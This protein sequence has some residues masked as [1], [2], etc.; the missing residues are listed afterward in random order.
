MANLIIKPNSATGDKLI[1]QDR[2]GGAVLTT[3]DSGVDSATSVI[4]TKTGTET[5][6]NKTLTT[7][8]IADLSNV[9]GT[10]SAINLENASYPAGHLLQVRHYGCT[11]GSVYSTSAAY[12]GN[13]IASGTFSPHGGGNNLSYM[14]AIL[15]VNIESIA[16]INESRIMLETT[17]SGADVLTNLNYDTGDWAGTYANQ[18]RTYGGK[19]AIS[20][21]IRLDGTGNADIDWQFSVRNTDASGSSAFT[22][23]KNQTGFA[24]YEYQG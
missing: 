5:L 23:Y 15:V 3:A 20:R 22:V 11:A 2:D 13:A 8:T 9:S 6:T 7:P 14:F 24:V 19:S 18:G 10:P 16:S 12:T 21:I 1:I 4:A 17:T